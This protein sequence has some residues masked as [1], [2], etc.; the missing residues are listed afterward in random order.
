MS[1]GEAHR[2]DDHAQA[3]RELSMTRPAV[4]GT[5]ECDLRPARPD[6]LVACARIWRASINDYLERLG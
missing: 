6:E 5:Q 4:R 2:A 1:G 3:E